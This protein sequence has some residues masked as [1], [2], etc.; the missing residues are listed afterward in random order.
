MEPS[1]GE[2]W[3]VDPLAEEGGAYGVRPDPS[4]GKTHG[5]GQR[6]GGLQDLRRGRGVVGPEVF[7]AEEVGTIVWAPNDGP[8]TGEDQPKK[9][10]LRRDL[11]ICGSRF[12]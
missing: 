1:G 6:I 11:P 4:R 7:R 12:V 5:I 2:G 8:E 3:D 10:L 9:D